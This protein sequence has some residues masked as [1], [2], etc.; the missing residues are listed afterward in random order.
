M[1]QPNVAHKSAPSSRSPIEQLEQIDRWVNE[2]QECDSSTEPSDLKLSVSDL[3]SSLVHLR[4]MLTERDIE[5]ERSRRQSESLAVAQAD[6]IVRS[7][8]IID[9]LEQIKKE[10]SDARSA[11]EQSA[12]DTKRLADTIFERTS[13]SVMVFDN[14]GCSACNDN[15]LEMFRVSRGEMLHSGRGFFHALKLDDGTDASDTLNTCLRETDQGQSQHFEA[16]VTRH[17]GTTFWAEFTF[18]PFVI[19]GGGQ[20]LAIVR[21]ITSRKQ[22]EAELR[23]HRDFLNKIVSAVPDQLSV[24]ASDHRIVVANRAFLNAHGVTEDE[25]IGKLPDEIDVPGL[26]EFDPQIDACFAG[27]VPQSTC[28]DSWIDDQGC[29]HYSANRYSAFTD[30]SSSDRF[31]IATSRDITDDRHREHRLQLLAS[32]FEESAEG[33]AILD[34]HGRI[35]EANPAFARMTNVGT[36]DEIAGKRFADLIH[37]ETDS[38]LRHVSNAANGKSWSGKIRLASDSQISQ[39]MQRTFWVSLSPSDGNVDRQIIALASDITE[40]E[41]SQAQLHHRAMHDSLTGCPNRAFFREMIVNLVNRKPSSN[42]V[43]ESFSICFLDLDDFKHVNDSIGHAGGDQLLQFVADR[44]IAVV[45]SDAFVARFGGDEFAILFRDVHYDLTTQEQLLAELI[46][47]FKR[48]FALTEAEAHVGLSIGVTRFPQDSTDTEMLMSYADTAM[49]SAKQAGKNAVAY[50]EPSMKQQV[51]MRQQVQTKL[52]GAITN[53]DVELHYQPK[54]NATTK[55]LVS[56]EALVRWRDSEGQFV[57][58]STFIPIAENSGL[59]N[60]LGEYVFESAAKQAR[61]WH[62]QGKP[63]RIA[64]NVSPIQLRSVD[65]AH[66]L[67]RILERT[68]ADPEWLELEIT[69]NAIMSNVEHSTMVIDKLAET[70]FRIAI[71]DFGTGHSSLSYLKTFNVHTLKI[72]LSFIRDVV[73]DRFSRSIVQSIISLGRGLGLTIVAEGVEVIEQVEYLAKLRCDELQGYF[74]GKPM[75]VVDFENWRKQYSPREKKPTITPVRC[76]EW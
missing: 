30:E 17:D 18:S 6:A 21:D 24:R 26:R 27:D 1:S 32:V 16:Q 60:A 55:E 53:G 4:E 37:V 15:A 56:C 33:V 42:D 25:I 31:V 67:V 35:L 76:F 74:F 46:N 23:R 69:E 64:V 71:D 58:P 68:G 34:I 20:I 22:F 44:I 3:T 45:G 75:P 39:H 7:A 70:G 54:V 41:N 10:L 8:E 48:P 19:S 51:D 63:L 47:E 5:L 65:F 40:L 29:K 13:D 2:I 38:I 66:S 52:R 57:P 9:E 59:I 62:D 72:D 49:Y 11:A 73:H 12:K 61:L 50:F 14:Q 28:V 36:G 43:A